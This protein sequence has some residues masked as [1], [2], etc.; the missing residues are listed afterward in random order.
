[1]SMDHNRFWRIID[2]ARE[3]AGSWEKMR[4]PLVQRLAGLDLADILLWHG[5]FL[6]YQSL[7]YKQKL[8]AA[9]YVIGGG[10][11]DD[12]FDYFCGW[13]TAQGREVFLGALSDPDS[14][15]DVEAC[16]GDVEFEYML[17]VAKD[18]YCR[19]FPERDADRFYT[20]TNIPIPDSVRQAMAA[21]IRYADDIDTD[22]DEDA[23]PD[24]FPKLC[25]AFD[26]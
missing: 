21:E 4:D 12:G 5:I 8:W 24:L 16:D 1:M 22:W 18:A 20:E 19:K 7:S 25:K 6:E 3:K 13:L 15:A 10:C 11:S 14:L 9:A 17:S 2:E 23:L 26:W